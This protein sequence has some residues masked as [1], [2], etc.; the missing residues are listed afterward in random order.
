MD[1]EHVFTSTK[2]VQ[3]GVLGFLA[4]KNMDAMYLPDLW[5]S[6]SRC[7]VM[8]QHHGAWLGRDTT[9]RSPQKWITYNRSNHLGPIQA[10]HNVAVVV[11]DPFSFF[12][13]RWAMAGE[14]ANVYTS[15]GTALSD[16]LMLKLL[17]HHKRVIVFYD[18]DDA[19]Y[20]GAARESHRLRSCGIEAVAACAGHGADPKDMTIGAIRAV[21]ARQ[22]EVV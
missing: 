18:G 6:K 12:K 2:A 1:M 10:R 11:E 15:L 7:R 19:G 22:L 5:Y 8:I 17:K 9:E 20:S 16:E 13:V 14:G 21:L 4:S 3:D